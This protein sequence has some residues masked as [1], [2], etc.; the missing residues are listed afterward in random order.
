MDVDGKRK[1]AYLVSSTNKSPTTALKVTVLQGL[2]PSVT[3][4]VQT[5]PVPT[6]ALPVPLP[7]PPDL[8]P[9]VAGDGRVSSSPKLRVT[10]V[11]GRGKR[12][13]RLYVARGVSKDG[14]TN[15]I[16]VDILTV[17]RAKAR[18]AAAVAPV[19]AFEGSFTIFSAIGVRACVMIKVG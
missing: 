15:G 18:G 19:V 11:K 3:W 16:A 14:A 10:R 8:L 5:I 9:N 17:G 4:S 7:Q 6:W 12:Q 13:L 1:E 2:P